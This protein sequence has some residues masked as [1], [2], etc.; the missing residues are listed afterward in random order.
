[1]HKLL[2]IFL[3]ALGALAFD[4]N[5]PALPDMARQ[6]GLSVTGSHAALLLFMVGM[7]M[8]QLLWDWAAGPLGARRM[9][10]LALLLLG[11]GSLTCYLA[12]T[13]PTLLAGRLLQG[14]GAGGT[15]A[16]A[17]LL[18]RQ[19]G[20]DAPSVLGTLLLPVCGPALGALLVLHGD[21]RMTFLPIAFTTLL[22][23]PCAGQLAAGEQQAARQSGSFGRLLRNADYLRYAGCQALCFGAWMA[24]AAAVPFLV[25][26]EL[27]LD[28]RHIAALLVCGALGQAL[29]VML[30]HTLTF[31]HGPSG[32]LLAGVVFEWVAVNTLLALAFEFDYTVIMLAGA[33]FVLGLG[34]GMRATPTIAGALQAAGNDARAGLALLM[35]LCYACAT[36]ATWLTAQRLQSA[37]L[38]GVAGL[39]GVMVM[40]GTMLPPALSRLGQD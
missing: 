35:F 13:A 23:L 29:G 24:F 22:L 20:H 1:M 7:A 38:A 11:L 37:G 10:A 21:W 30:I 4:I 18:L 8:A 12:A 2:L 5:L 9:L 32:M 40:V 16:L 31:R 33:W 17:P 6:F 3:A 34:M 15:A 36:A 28:A 19:A 27:R 14:L 39:M 25:S 26:V